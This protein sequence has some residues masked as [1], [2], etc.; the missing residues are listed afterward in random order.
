MRNFQKLLT[1]IAL[2]L[3][4]ATAFAEG[5][6]WEDSYTLEELGADSIDLNIPVGSIDIREVNTDSVRLMVIIDEDLDDC[7]GTDSKEPELEASL[8]AKELAINLA[9]DDCKAKV[10][11]DVPQGLD[12][13]VKLGVGEVKYSGSHSASIKVGVGTVDAH[14]NSTRYRL[15]DITTGLGDVN[16]KLRHGKTEENSMAFLANEL[17][18][19]GDGEA[20]LAVK[21]GV[22][23]VDIR[24]RGDDK[25]I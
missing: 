24:D 5:Y 18:W 9:A 14:V 1:A 3:S 23:T 20:Y 16:V 6:H 15:I 12:L 19:R 7:S 13:D 25:T 4:S 17:T 8:E 10:N 22:G 21:A 2:S 11:L